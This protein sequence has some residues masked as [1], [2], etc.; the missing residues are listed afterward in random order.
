MKCYYIPKIRVTDHTTCWQGWKKWQNNLGKLFSSFLK[1]W[2]YTPHIPDLPLLSIYLTEIKAFI[3][4]KTDLHYTAKETLNKLKRQLRE[5][6]EVFV[7]CVSDKVLIT[8][9]YEEVMQINDKNNNN[10]KQS[11]L[12]V[13]WG[14]GWCDPVD[15][16]P[17]CKPKGRHFYSQSGHMP[18]LQTRSPVGGV[19][20]AT[21][22]WCFSSSLSPCLPP[23][24]KI[25][26]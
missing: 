7:Y 3:H 14:P 4:T 24:L 16:V 8:K 18:G 5:W 26:K 23:S 9:I 13:G 1:S 21:T 17:A 10:N 12:K 20:E 2:T 22:C 25:S 19:W 11:T 15:W 6:E